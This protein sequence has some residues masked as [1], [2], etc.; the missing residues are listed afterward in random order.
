MTIYNE[1]LKLNI[2]SLNAN[3]IQGKKRG[4]KEKKEENSRIYFNIKRYRYI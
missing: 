4:Y 2:L 1:L 3:R